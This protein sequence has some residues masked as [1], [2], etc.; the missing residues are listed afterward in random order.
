[1]NRKSFLILLILLI[2][3]GGCGLYLFN[4][5]SGSWQGAKTG[6]RPFQKLDVNQVAQ[7]HLQDG[8]AQT[9]LINR[10]GTWTIKE[11]DGARANFDTVRNLLIKLPEV[12]VVQTQTVDASLLPRLDLIEPA[13]QATGA[14]DAAATVGTRFELQDKSG[15]TMAGL[16]LGKT[17]IKTESSPLAVKPTSAVGRY[18]M[19]SGAPTV[20]LISDALTEAQADPAHWLAPAA[21]PVGS[22]APA[23]G[24]EAPAASPATLPAI[25]QSPAVSRAAPA[26]TPSAP[27]ASPTA[28]AASS[29][30][31]ATGASGNA[32]AAVH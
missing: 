24:S 14:T 23:A 30:A 5:N 10:D 18:V 16:L 13:A 31:P 9:T 7:I 1:M 8:H 19:L 6:A 11:R 27:L 26:G 25:P 17:V 20:L 28:P 2:V 21:A 4:R 22:G 32:P 12:K 3:V 15:K 29:A